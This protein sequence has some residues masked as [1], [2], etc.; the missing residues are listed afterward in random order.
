[1]MKKQLSFSVILVFLICSATATATEEAS[2]R[3]WL[4]WFGET[5]HLPPT[6]PKWDPKIVKCF[7]DFQVEKKCVG[8]LI[9]SIW[10]HNVSLIGPECCDSV[11]QLSEDCAATGFAGLTHS[12]Y[13]VVLKDYCS[14]VSPPPSAS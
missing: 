6:H 4:K 10:N 5:E 8:E 14:H 7:Q 9:A 11:N 2:K 3:A 13:A 12:F 1:M